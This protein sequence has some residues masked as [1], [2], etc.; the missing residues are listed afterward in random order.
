MPEITGINSSRVVAAVE[1]L[2]DI[3]KF[4][5]GKAVVIGGGDVGCETACYMADNGFDV[6]IV[7][8]QPKLLEETKDLNVKLPL[9]NLICKE[10]S[11]SILKQSQTRQ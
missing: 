9:L 5:K 3:S 11:K 10:I 4:K 1:V 8:I 7:E 2:R 6:S